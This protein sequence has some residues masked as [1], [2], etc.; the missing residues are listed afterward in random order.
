MV[1]LLIHD[2]SRP[3]ETGKNNHLSLEQGK[4]QSIEDAC[5]LDKPGSWCSKVDLQSAY[6]SLAIHPDDYKVTV[7]KWKFSGQESAACLFYTRLPFGARRGPAIFHH[8]SEAVRS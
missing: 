8:I 1:I 7:L 2:V 4:F 3:V 6:F 5:K